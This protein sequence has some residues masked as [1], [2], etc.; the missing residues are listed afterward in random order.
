MARTTTRD[1]PEV[2]IPE[3]PSGVLGP[4]LGS[5]GRLVNKVK[6]DQVINKERS[7]RLRTV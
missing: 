5:S 4:M 7:S 1:I 2:Y 6:H 3:V